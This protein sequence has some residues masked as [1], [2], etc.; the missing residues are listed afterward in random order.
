MDFCYSVIPTFTWTSTFGF[1]LFSTSFFILLSIKGLRI[2]WSYCTISV[3]LCSFSLSD[4]SAVLDPERSNH[5]SKSS[6][7]V[8]TSG[9]KKFNK[10]HNSCK[11]FW[12]G[13][14]VRRSLNLESRVLSF[15]EIWDSS[16]LILCA[17]STIKYSHLNF[18]NY[19]KQIL[20]P[21]KVV[22]TTSNLPGR[23]S[24]FRISSLCS[25]FA[26]KFTTLIE[27]HHFLNSFIQ[28]G[29][30]DLGT[31][32]KWYPFTCLYSLKNASKDIV[33]IVFPSPYILRSEL[34]NNELTISSANIP[35][36]PVSY[37]PMSQ[38]SPSSW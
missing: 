26:I 18:C 15:W 31:M 5:S 6:A 14:P 25:F 19:D 8:N 9:N 30:V 13:V 21:S 1:K 11:L 28:L 2:L 29:K 4:N 7:D 22:K 27:G 10:L 32:T 24:F 3:F 38:L 16:F 36:M 12:R 34:L 35:F 23:R 33:W 20:Q 37:N 17:S